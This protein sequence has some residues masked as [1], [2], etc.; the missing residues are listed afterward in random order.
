[1]NK[2]LRLGTLATALLL[3]ATALYVG[4]RPAYALCVCDPTTYDTYCWGKGST[5]DLATSNLSVA[6]K[7]SADQYCWSIGADSSCNVVTTP[8]SY[9]WWDPNSGAWVA[10]G[11]ATFHCRY[12]SD[13]EPIPKEP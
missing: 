10:S 1:M 12:C 9:P 2:N 4:T 6:C 8:T 13:R 3:V 11:H 7:A 5:T